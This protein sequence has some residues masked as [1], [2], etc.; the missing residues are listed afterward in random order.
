MKLL[1][2]ECDTTQKYPF[3]KLVLFTM[4]SIALTGYR[5]HCVAAVSHS[6]FSCCDILHGVECM[7]IHKSVDK[8]GRDVWRQ[9]AGLMGVGNVSR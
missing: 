3:N 7:S 8:M 4:V 1:V 6:S 5:N 2:F 9:S